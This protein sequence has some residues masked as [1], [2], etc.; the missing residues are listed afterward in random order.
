MKK[1]WLGPLCSSQRTCSNPDRFF[2]GASVCG[3]SERDGRKPDFMRL[4]TKLSPRRSLTVV[5]GFECNGLL[6]T[7]ERIIRLM[8]ARSV[9][10]VVDLPIVLSEL[11]S[12][13][14][15]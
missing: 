12:E 15:G 4:S 1:N 11:G 6:T 13:C 14:N 7:V 10:A 9:V 8:V 3:A 2:I 5:G